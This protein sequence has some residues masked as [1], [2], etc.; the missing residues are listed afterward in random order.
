LLK[1][2]NLFPYVLIA[3]SVAM[4]LALTA[5]PLFFAL[6]SSVY[7][8]NLQMSP[9][10]LAF[11]GLDNFATT[12]SDPV[13]LQS[14][15][16]TVVLT[17]SGT[18]VEVGLGLC[19]ALLLTRAL[20]GM[21]A[22]RAILIMPTTIAPIVVGFLFRYMYDPTGGIIPWLLR[23]LWI[24][25]PAA[26]LLG[27]GST[28]LASILFADAWQWTPFC[29]IVLYAALLTVPHEVLEAARLDGASGWT[30]VTRIKVPL[31][32]K[33]M[34]FVVMLR[35][36]QLFNTFDLVLVLTRG[37]PGTASRTL[38]YSLYQ[39]GLVDFNIG[40]ASATTWV[41]VV[42]VNAMIALYVFFIFRDRE[43]GR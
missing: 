22:A 29:A 39:Q 3:P 18:V 16:N 8:W 19:I 41:I 12:L 25:V 10:P 17:A 43:P 42:L 7:F 36:M 26:G 13:F 21:N 33:T 34:A 32:R 20:P 24:P 23:T 11:I 14:L 31:I 38:G 37:G 6:S 2:S 28:A 27:S 4:L 35:S 1:R 30:L 40:L 5:F 15:K 9:R